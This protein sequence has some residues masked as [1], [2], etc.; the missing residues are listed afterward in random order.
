MPPPTDCVTHHEFPSELIS[1][2]NR[3]YKMFGKVLK[4]LN[5]FFNNACEVHAHS[6]RTQCKQHVL[7]YNTKAA[8]IRA[9]Q[10]IRN[11]AS[12]PL[13][14][15]IFNPAELWPRLRLRLRAHSG[16]SL[17]C[18]CSYSLHRLCCAS[19][20]NKEHRLVEL[21]SLHRFCCATVR[22]A[23]AAATRAR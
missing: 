16:W 12:C 18:P 9:Q 10:N 15:P 20:R 8:L 11:P 5:F 13:E 23:S 14:I 7:P 6:V 1:T 2:L 21:T 22:P 19:V 4:P 17:P 3:T